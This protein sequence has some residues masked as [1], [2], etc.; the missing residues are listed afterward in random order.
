MT[1]HSILVVDDETNVLEATRQLLESLGYTVSAAAGGRQALRI[2]NQKT[3]D[4]VITDLLMPEMDGFELITALHEKHPGIP[5]VAMSGGGNLSAEIYLKIAKG[6]R[7]DWLLKKPFARD[8]LLTA[9]KVV[10]ARASTSAPPRP[11]KDT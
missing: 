6:F 4:L 5:I 8:E 10:E 2:L 7:V 3:A 11:P 9:V 1:I